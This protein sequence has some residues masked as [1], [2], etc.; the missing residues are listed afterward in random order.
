MIG[1]IED[2]LCGLNETD[3]IENLEIEKEIDGGF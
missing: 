1:L 2:E 3:L